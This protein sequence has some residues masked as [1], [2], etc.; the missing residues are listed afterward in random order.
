MVYFPMSVMLL[1]L[2]LIAF[3]DHKYRNGGFAFSPG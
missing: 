3:I 1:L 2:N